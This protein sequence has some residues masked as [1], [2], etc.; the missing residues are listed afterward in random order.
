MNLLLRFRAQLLILI[1]ATQIFSSL[2]FVPGTEAFGGSLYRVLLVLVAGLLLITRGVHHVRPTTRHVLAAGLLLTVW[3]LLSLTWSEDVGGGVR[4]ISYVVTAILLVYV[5]DN[6]VRTPK[7]FGTLA[8]TIIALGVGII[9]FAFYELET[10]NHFPSALLTV[11]DYDSSLSYMTEN[12]AWFTF[13]NP[14]DLAVHIVICAFVAAI[15]LGG[16]LWR[17]APIL[18]F[19]GI[20]MYLSD[21]LHARLVLVA[22]LVFL[23]VYLTC[24]LHN[25]AAF[26]ALAASGASLVGAVLVGAALIMGARAEFI[27]TST[28]IRLELLTSAIEISA[29]SLMV[30][31]GTGGF[32][33][34][35]VWGGFV[36]RT[37]GV[38]SPH[39]AFGRIF[40]ENGIIGLGL[41]TY[42]L[43]GPLFLLGRSTHTT[44]LTAFVGASTVALPLL[45]SSGSDPLSSSSLGFFIALIWIAAGV[46]VE[47]DP[48]R[49]AVT[50]PLQTS[51]NPGGRSDQ[52]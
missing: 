17:I 48:S 19:V 7:D 32:E 52:S 2:L 29:R 8:L 3:M 41:F 15:Y 12:L 22:G 44:K 43:F 1:A 25:R 35:L 10:G 4:Q 6:L 30:G 51:T 49:F 11:D 28:F 14:N 16:S 24:F 37:Y 47:N 31:I 39:N 21:I 38:L 23:A 50:G 18:L 26:G 46:A 27:D 34:H 33:T 45:L 42:M 40:A 20:G 9:A 5:L 13:G 36:G